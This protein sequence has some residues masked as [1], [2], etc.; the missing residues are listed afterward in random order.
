[1]KKIILCRIISISIK[2]PPPSSA[3]QNNILRR[4]IT[5]TDNNGAQAAATDQ[6]HGDGVRHIRHDDGPNTGDDRAKEQ[7]V[8]RSEDGCPI[9]YYLTPQTMHCE[10]GLP[11]RLPENHVW[12]VHSQY[13]NKEGMTSWTPPDLLRT[14]L[15][16]TTDRADSRPHDVCP[17]TA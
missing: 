10:I 6:A 16:S 13:K 3:H 15:L 11:E 8:M 7:L 4:I 2:R 5:I 1:M 9:E 17:Y 14:S 12:K